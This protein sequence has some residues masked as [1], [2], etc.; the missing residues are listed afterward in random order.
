[1]S[2]KEVKVRYQILVVGAGGTG[3]YFLKEFS[4]YLSGNTAARKQIVSL[5]VADGDMVEEKNLARQAFESADIGQKK[6]AVMASILS[7]AFGLTWNS[8]SKYLTN[9]KQIEELFKQGRLH[10]GCYDKKEIVPVIIGCVDNHA[11]RLLCETFFNSEKD[12]IY[13]DSAN[14][15]SSGEIIFASRKKGKLVSPLRS[16]IFPDILKADKR[17]VE[18]MSCTELNAAAPQHIAVNM[19]AGLYLLSAVTRLLETGVVVKGIT[20]FDVLNMD[21][22]HFDT[23]SGLKKE[24]S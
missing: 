12:C 7:D 24:A 4:R 20:M 15:F 18:E 8:Y 2:K 23:I 10:A 16:M 17:N 6:A 1:M 5:T 19:N 21:S 14:E 9:I 13:F 3:T 11:C 22:Q